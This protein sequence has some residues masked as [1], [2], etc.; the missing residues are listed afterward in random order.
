MN[1][2]KLGHISDI[3]SYRQKNDDHALAVTNPFNQTLLVV[4]DGLGGY[5]NGSLASEIAISTL[6][7]SFL[8]TDF[9]NFKKDDILKWFKKNIW[10]AQQKITVIALSS[11]E[12]QK[13][14]TTVV[15]SLIVNDVVYTLNIG[16]SRAYLVNANNYQQITTD[17]NL[18]EDL[19][20]RN[21]PK[22]MFEENKK[23]LH[24]LTQFVGRISNVFLSFDLYEHHLQKGEMIVLTSDGFH[25]FYDFKDFWND[26]FKND[27]NLE[28][29]IKIALANQSN[30]N[31]SISYIYKQ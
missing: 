13:M 9:S 5:K 15:A 2:V 8:A 30:D 17:H 31:L 21:A 25:N 18:Y 14:A 12:N 24:A 6:N 1:D 22:L 11:E 23:R 4:C 28:Q 19:V 29:M 16:D 7:E 26:I 3:G 20:K 27:F 10:N